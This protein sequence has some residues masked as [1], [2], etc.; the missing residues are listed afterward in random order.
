MCMALD[1]AARARRDELRAVFVGLFDELNNAEGT[2]P[3][4]ATVSAR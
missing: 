4:A 2:Y 1:E 3:A